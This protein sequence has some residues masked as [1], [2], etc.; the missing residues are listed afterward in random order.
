MAKHRARLTMTVSLEMNVETPTGQEAYARVKDY[1]N[2]IL[3]T[4]WHFTNAPKEISGIS[5]SLY[6]SKI[7]FSLTP[8]QV[9]EAKAG[10]KLG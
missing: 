7:D 9:A 2:Q 10:L 4:E 5:E 6:M 1:E 8:E 3:T